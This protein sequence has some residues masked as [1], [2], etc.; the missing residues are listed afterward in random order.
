MVAT[1]SPLRN[2]NLEALRTIA[3]D[4][5]SVI[6]YWLGGDEIEKQVFTE[7]V[8]GEKS[9]DPIIEVI[10]DLEE[11]I[12]DAVKKTMSLNE[13]KLTQHL[14]AFGKS[15][16]DTLK[17]VMDR[18]LKEMLDATVEKNLGNP[19]QDSNTSQSGILM[20][21]DRE[22]LRLLI[23]QN[24]KNNE[25]GNSSERTVHVSPKYEVPKLTSQYNFHGKADE[26]VKRWLK[27]VKLNMKTGKIPLQE[28][29]RVAACY[30]RD[31][32][33]N[34]YEAWA[35]TAGDDAERFAPFEKALLD[36]FLPK[37]YDVVAWRKLNLV[38]H[39]SSV[40]NYKAD[41][42]QA[43]DQMPPNAVN[44]ETLRL[45][46]ISSLNTVTR[47]Y[48][49]SKLTKTLEE[50]YVEAFQFEAA[51]PS[52]KYSEVNFNKEKKER[53]QC[54]TCGK[55]NHDESVCYKTHPELKKDKNRDEKKSNEPSNKKYEKDRRRDD[56][57]QNGKQYENYKKS[58]YRPKV[59]N[60]DEEDEY[61]ESELN[62]MKY[63]NDVNIVKNTSTG[64]SHFCR[65]KIEVDGYEVEAIF[66]SGANR[67][68]LPKK[69]V[70]KYDLPMKRGAYKC[71][72]AD[73]TT[74]ESFETKKLDVVLHGSITSLEMVVLDRQTALL[75][76]DWLN[77]NRAYVNTSS[78]TLTFEKREISLVEEV[79]PDE[80]FNVNIGEINSVNL[81]DEDLKEIEQDYEEES[82]ETTP[83]D[84][85]YVVKEHEVLQGMELEQL[86]KLLD[87]YRDSFASSIL[88]LGQPCNVLKFKV[89]LT[90]DIPVSQRFYNVSLAERAI[91][92]D[93]VKKMLEARIIRRSFSP[94]K[95]PVVLI[96][97]KDKSIRFCVDYRKLNKKTIKDNYP[98]PMIQNIFTRL[99]DSAWFTIA[100][101]K[102][103]YW[104]MQMDKDSIAK[105]AFVTC[106]GSYEFVVLPF[107]MSNGPAMFCRLMGMILGGLSF[108]EVYLDD[109]LIHSKTLKDHLE[110]IEIVFKC[111][112]KA[113]L[114]LN[115]AKCKWCQKAIKYLGH[116]ISKD[117]VK[118]DEDKVKTI[119]NWQEPRNLKQ[120]QQFLG[121]AGYYRKFIRDFAR[122]AAPLYALTKKDCNWKWNED[123]VDAFSKLKLALMSDPIL[124][125]PNFGIQFHIY[126][127]ASGL[128]VGGVLCQTEYGAEYVIAYASK[129]LKGAE[130]HYS[131]SEKEMLAVLYSIKTFRCYIFGTEFLIITDHAA[132]QY[133][134]NI[135]D[136]NGRL[137]RWSMYL[138]SYFFKIIHRAGKKHANADALSRAMV[139]MVDE[140]ELLTAK[141][142]MGVFDDVTLKN[143]DPWEN[144]QLLYFLENL[145]HMKGISKKQ[146]K[147]IAKVAKHFVLEVKTNVDG[148]NEKIL[149]YFHN[150]SNKQ[151]KKIY[152]RPEIRKLLIEDAHHLGHLGIEKT[153]SYLSQK[154]YWR[155]MWDQVNLYV[156][157]CLTCLRFKK[158]ITYDHPALALPIHDVMERIGIDL[159]LGLPLTEEGHNGILVITEYLSKYPYAVA[160]KSKSA[161]EI[162]RHL[163]EYFA[164]FGPAQELLSDCGKEFLNKVVDNLLELVGTVR[165]HTS[166]YHPR[167]SG[168]TE[169]FNK[170]LCNELRKHAEED[171][172]KWNLWLP[173]ALRSYRAMRHKTTK[174]TPYELF[175][176]RRTNEEVNFKVLP[177]EAEESSMVRREAQI[178]KH[179]E[180]IIPQ[181]VE[182]INKAQEK[183]KENQD[184]R[185][186]VMVQPLEK[187]TIV[188]VKVPGLLTKLEPRY[189]GPYK[190]AKQTPQHNYILKT[191]KG[192]PLKASFPL[193]KLKIVK[194]W[195]NFDATSCEDGNELDEI[196]KILND[197]V[198]DGM[199]QYLVKFKDYTN[200]HNK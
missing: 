123:C 96:T 12:K 186:N 80:I 45:M 136:L 13:K 153:A 157:N 129:I 65:T 34:A 81:S 90:D 108:V 139:N 160:I 86:N 104:Q 17:E 75:G 118:T 79:D 182:N 66:D 3:L 149:Y 92:N 116:I 131:T 124:R 28:Q 97:K 98:I 150:V 169:N 83:T 95:S 189:R 133:L 174:Y 64:K 181:A 121:L 41:F 199:K 180:E 117:V 55:R 200:D 185:Q 61:Q 53:K 59:N 107:G 44:N 101:M 134:L 152:P 120:L 109:I 190:I 48:V 25:G 184:K 72:L 60:V 2:L 47:E 78:L 192:K 148:T 94:F 50:A 4:K 162:A 175:F 31:T 106:D 39:T 62:I 43:A 141:Q 128:A 52:T 144:D 143:V 51:H 138:Q 177:L 33:S 145:K 82:W 37:N 103:G 140:V 88:D 179:Q 56:Q 113:S 5:A 7:M 23:I 193:C 84:V 38:R 114:K 91:I 76:I 6:G 70:E 142:M 132:L 115:F 93:E 69:F 18:R 9:K 195:Q 166:V 57:N 49:Q 71:Q 74:Y 176:G 119:K 135:K 127:D 111:L 54:K 146:M 89:N 105:T 178:Q 159:V 58:G 155:K 16:T 187:D 73:G 46:F 19:S 26:C 147:Y 29:V 36:R 198:K 167:C 171:R 137:A 151:E 197:R 168:L 164:L 183:Q 173:H 42:D 15:Q 163:L 112:K 77:A 40:T 191:M 85:E 1:E 8:Y 87:K 154:Y 32:A 172:E 14:A 100:D 156:N 126:C 22:L 125:M 194:D 188:F 11:R 27:H 170:T 99:K 110:H 67:S 35:D 20:D 196:E 10:H 102:S 161:K 122:I 68:V 24:G 21:E 30:L 158:G 130:I 165:R 63:L